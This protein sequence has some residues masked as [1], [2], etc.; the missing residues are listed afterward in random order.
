M[1]FR[2]FPVNQDRQVQY[3][4]HYSLTHVF[5]GFKWYKA[6][7]LYEKSFWHNLN[8]GRMVFSNGKVYDF[9]PVFL[10]FIC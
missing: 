4:V 3:L 2:Y 9:S 10:S 1:F 8:F 6:N 5:Y 7:V